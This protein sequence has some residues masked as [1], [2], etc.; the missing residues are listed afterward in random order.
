[1]EYAIGSDGWLDGTI[2]LVAADNNVAPD[3]VGTQYAL[4]SY[5]FRAKTQNGAIVA[6]TGQWTGGSVEDHPDFAWYP[7]VAVAEN[8]EIDAANIS[9]IVGFAVAGGASPPTPQ[10]G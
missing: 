7:Y 2:Q 9:K 6:G 1:M 5:T 10:S 8:P 4:H 3:F